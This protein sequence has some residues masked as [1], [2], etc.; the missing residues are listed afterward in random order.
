MPAK[1]ARNSG[2]FWQRQISEGHMQRRADDQMNAG[3]TP[4]QTTSRPPAP[5]KPVGTY[6]YDAARH[7][8]TGPALA[9]SARGTRPRFL[10]SSNQ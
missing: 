4:E 10:A 8:G 7:I 1:C 3:E 6:A 2:D 9:G 5:K